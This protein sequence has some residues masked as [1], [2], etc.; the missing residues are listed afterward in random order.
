VKPIDF[1]FQEHA[2]ELRVFF[3]KIDNKPTPSLVLQ[4]TRAMMLLFATFHDGPGS[5]VAHSGSS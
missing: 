5:T 4:P 2:Q 1:I 3:A